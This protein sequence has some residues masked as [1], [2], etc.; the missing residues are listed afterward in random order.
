MNMQT[1][2][3]LALASCLAITAFPAAAD[4]V[5]IYS[6]TQ[7][8]G[9]LGQDWTGAWSDGW[10]I[11]E[12]VSEVSISADTLSYDYLAGGAWM[13]T[14]TQ[15]YVFSTTAARDGALALD[16]ALSSN[17]LWNGSA[18]SMYI[19]HGSTDTRQLLAGA[20]G[21][22]VVQTSVTL[23][24]TQG[25]AWGFMAV[26]GSVNDNLDYTGDLYGSFTVTAAATGPAPGNDV[27]EPASMALLGLGMLGLAAVRR[28]A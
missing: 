21:D 10:N 22:A 19:W 8:S 28:K 2:R 1:L 3:S 18:T 11:A 9:P 17:A 6:S 20:T 14:P 7:G 23:D 25:E 24:L 12:Y 26:S 4:P 16:I 5:W 27:P 15:T 13:G